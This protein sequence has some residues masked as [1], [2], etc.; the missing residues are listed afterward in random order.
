MVRKTDNRFQARAIEIVFDEH[1]D[2]NVIIEHYTKTLTA[3]L[4]KCFVKWHTGTEGSD[5]SS[6][7]H[8]GLILR[9]KPKFEYH[10]LKTIFKV[11]EVEPHLVN[12]IGKGNSSPIKKLTKYCAY[13]CDGHDNGR[14]NDYWHY[15][16]DY[17]YDSQE[18][19]VGKVLCLL[20]RG[21]NY[22]DIYTSSAWDF[23]ADMTKNRKAII[24]AWNEFKLIM[25]KGPR[26]KLRNWQTKIDKKVKSPANDRTVLWV[27]SKAEEQAGKTTL[28]KQLAVH[29][30]ALYLSNG[31]DADL[32]RA[33]DGQEIVCFNFTKTQDEWVNYSAMEALKDGAIF[34]SKYDSGSKIFAPPSV[35]VFANFLPNTDCMAKDRWEIYSVE[36]QKLV[37]RPVK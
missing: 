5:T 37:H 29:D 11:G 35:V 31:S 3:G 12:P 22:N 16:F 24:T 10:L 18:S 26:K 23:R 9:E 8:V 13:C 32:A 27:H 15:K 21:S 20:S 1:L 6:H 34:S 4:Y 30:G 19:T 36:N 33:Y 14:F 25:R 17:E 2:G 7:T 28:A